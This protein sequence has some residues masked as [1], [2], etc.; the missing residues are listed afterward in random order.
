MFAV[1]LSVC[2]FRI[3][4]YSRNH[5]TYTSWSALCETLWGRLAPHSTKSVYEVF[6]WCRWEFPNLQPPMQ[7]EQVD[8]IDP[9]DQVN[10]SRSVGNGDDDKVHDF[11][12]ILRLSKC[13]G[14][15]VYMHHRWWMIDGR[16]KRVGVG[17]TPRRFEGRGGGSG[18]LAYVA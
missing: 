13:R 12:I 5:S 11:A 6:W 2:S 10:R 7:T 1:F 17:G 8:K 18:R 15:G 14:G 4:S 9:V 16:V 3:A